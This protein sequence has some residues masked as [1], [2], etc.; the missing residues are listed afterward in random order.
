MITGSSLPRRMGS[1]LSRLVCPVLLIVV[2]LTAGIP[3]EAFISPA[4][5]PVS[6][7]ASLLQLGQTGSSAHWAQV[8]DSNDAT[9]VF[10]KNASWMTDRYNLADSALTGTI[11]SV[12]VHMRVGRPHNWYTTESGA[13]TYVRT[14]AGVEHFGV[15]QTIPNPPTAS[16]WSWAEY[17]TTYYVVP[18]TSAAWTWADVNRL[19]V[20][21]S[22]K[23]SGTTI[24]DSGPDNTETRCSKIWVVVEYRAPFAIAPTSLTTAEGGSPATFTIRLEHKPTAPVTIGLTSSDASEGTVSPSSVVF[25]ADTPASQVRRPTGDGYI[26]GTWSPSSGR[27]QAVDEDPYNDGDY[28]RGDDD[29]N[30]GEYALFTF[31][32]FNVPSNAYNISVTVH[33]RARDN[34]W[35][36]FSGNMIAAAVQVNGSRYYGTGHNAPES[37]QSYGQYSY[38]WNVNPY[39]GYGWAWVP[40]DINGSVAGIELQQFGVYSNDLAPNIRVSAV[41]AEVNYTV[42]SNYNVP[43]TVTVTP[44]DDQIDDGDVAYWIITAPAASADPFY[45]GWN[46]DD[47]RVT[48]TDN[49][50]SGIVLSQTSLMTSEGGS[51]G[52]F[53]V[54]LNS[55][56]TANVTIALG[57]SDTTEGTVSP[58]TLTFLAGYSGP[59]SQT[60][61]PT[62]VYGTAGGTW[63]PY[64]AQALHLCVD[65][66]PALTAPADI[67]ADY[68]T[69]PLNASGGYVLFSYDDFAIPSNATD[70]SVTVYYRARD[71]GT[72]GTNSIRPFI[73]IGGNHFY[74]T[75][76]NP[77]GS[78]GL[79]GY[80]WTVNPILG[81]PWTEA[82]I[83]G[84]G[85]CPRQFGVHFTDLDPAIDVSRVMM[86][87][88]YN[89]TVEPTWH[90][91]QTV[92]VRPV[93]D[94]VKDGNIT[95]SITA[96][97]T[98]G[99]YSGLT[100]NVSVINYD[101]Q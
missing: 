73:S 15:A 8:G 23:R 68:I 67:D 39:G 82:Q 7:D 79:G 5:V 38:T 98:G 87:V 83:N 81:L 69:S 95:Y 16:Q 46:P 33:F 96:T 12:T 72:V 25:T 18:G 53:T 4:L 76:S 51:S 26:N 90:I 97:A 60:R 93:N 27:Y 20:G 101:Q 13:R 21:V 37:S 89:Y 94:F 29:N 56:P 75:A 2:L 40:Q 58:S 41:W 91:P 17:N 57:S 71:N 84:G 92:T 14:G 48:N 32:A 19:Q 28:I 78:F 55:Q 1:R 70:I 42:P 36:A 3:A 88:S 62:G 11:T 24:G 44:V 22:L 30:C 86:Q 6:D 50:T 43:Q 65:D 31:P 34:A 9:Y 47:V 85:Y 74:G 59:G 64:G 61:V 49:D 66:H 54:K 35:A 80:T 52:Q 99:D 10:T 63:T 77:S 45:N 100:A